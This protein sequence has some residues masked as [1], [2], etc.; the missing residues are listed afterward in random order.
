M[1]VI[2]SKNIDVNFRPKSYFRPQK[3]EQFLLSK[4]QNA[5]LRNQL[6]KLFDKGRHDEAVQIIQSELNSSEDLKS[7]EKI[8]PMFMGG[9]Y[10]PDTDEGEIEIARISIMSTTL[11]VTCVYAKPVQGKIELRVV[12]EYDG[13]TLSFP[14]EITIENP[15]SLGEFTDFFL[16][17]W[18]LMDVLEM[19]FE[20]DVE[21]ALGFFS[22]Q[23]KYYPDLDALC[24]E[25]VILHFPEPDDSDEE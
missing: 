25:R 14:T 19:N 17:A 5:V 6:E 16:T 20:S 22:A 23:S 3:I 11:D 13:D 12:D 2:V 7:L 18:P 1:E 4:V 8:H 9:N 24:R 15:M 21:S 10:L